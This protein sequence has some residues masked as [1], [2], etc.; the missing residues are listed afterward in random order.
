MVLQICPTTI[1]A[2]D[3]AGGGVVGSGHPTQQPA[4]VWNVRVPENMEKLQLTGI[5]EKAR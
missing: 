2:G 1:R 5:P 4:G 3:W